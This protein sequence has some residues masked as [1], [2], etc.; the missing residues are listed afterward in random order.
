MIILNSNFYIIELLWE[1]FS[2]EPFKPMKGSQEKR[3][4]ILFFTNDPY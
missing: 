1:R 2:W 4:I 3:L